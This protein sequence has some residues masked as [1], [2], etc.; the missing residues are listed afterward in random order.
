MTRIKVRNFK[1]DGNPA[2]GMKAYFTDDLLDRYGYGDY[3]YSGIINKTVFFSN[4][5]FSGSIRFKRRHVRDGSLLLINS[6]LLNQSE[7]IPG[8]NMIEIYEDNDDLFFVVNGNL[9]DVV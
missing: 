6:V 5:G 8:I 3:F 1:Y 7:I 2:K 4:E 9:G